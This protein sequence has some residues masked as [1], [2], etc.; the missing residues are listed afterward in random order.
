MFLFAKLVLTNLYSQT[1][2]AKLYEEL[3]PEAFPKG[4]EQAYANFFNLK[5]ELT[6]ARYSRIVTRVLHNPIEAERD[7]ARK[8]LGWVLSAKRPLKWHEIQGAVSIDTDNQCVNFEDRQLRVHVKDLCGSLVEILP[9]DRVTLV[10][11]TAEM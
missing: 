3:Q 4:F 5:L 8:L 11:R 10:H 1:S 9:G 7:D 2:K 6:S